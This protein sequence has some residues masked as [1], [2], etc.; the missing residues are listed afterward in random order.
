MTVK[1]GKM[2]IISAAKQATIEEPGSRKGD[3]HQAYVLEHADTVC[4]Y[5]RDPNMHCVKPRCQQNQKKESKQMRGH[6]CIR[7][8]KELS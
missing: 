2:Y 6:A 4:E 8:Y 1:D 3:E 7:I 5:K